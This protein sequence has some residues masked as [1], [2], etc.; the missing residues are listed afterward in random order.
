MSKKVLLIVAAVALLAMT[1]FAGDYKY[2]DWP[3]ES[4]TK[5]VTDARK[6]PL[7]IDTIPVHI[8]IP[9]YVDIDPQNTEIM[10]EQVGQSPDSGSDRF[11]FY[12]EAKVQS[13]DNAGTKPT[14]K[15]NFNGNLSTKLT[16]TADGNALST[17]GNNP[18]VWTHG[19]NPSAVTALQWE[20]LTIWC[21][22]T[23]VKL[24]AFVECS[25]KHVADI[26]LYITATQ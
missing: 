23:K 7:L 15:T 10:L 13:G 26:E 8:H 19:V 24:L 22:V 14:I 11:E 4:Y 17:G 12:G 20:V 5:T 16:K 21:R 6:A 25:T 2:E 3:T 1:A 9:Y 18:S